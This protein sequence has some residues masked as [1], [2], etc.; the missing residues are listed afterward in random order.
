MR[1]QSIVRHE[2]RIGLTRLGE[3]SWAAAVVQEASKILEQ[4]LV[5]DLMGME[6]E[7]A[8]SLAR[9]CGHY[10]NLTSIA[11]THHRYQSCACKLASS[12]ASACC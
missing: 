6:L 8:I 12:G 9:A 3:R 5:D 1:C 2:G 7:E 10:L 4:K 11:E